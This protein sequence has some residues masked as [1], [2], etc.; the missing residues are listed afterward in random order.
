VLA[1]LA[2]E[3][4][5]MAVLVQISRFMSIC[6]IGKVLDLTLP[7]PSIFEAPAGR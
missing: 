7:V 5:A 6:T 2:G 4:F 1:A 3:P